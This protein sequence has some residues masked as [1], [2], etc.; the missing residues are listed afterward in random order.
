MKGENTMKG[1]EIINYIVRE[2]MP[3]KEQVRENCHRLNFKEE[4]IAKKFVKKRSFVIIAITAV[5]AV[6]LVTTA[7]AYGGE[8]ITVIQQFMFG[9]SS[10][11]QVETIDG[12]DEVPALICSIRALIGNKVSATYGSVS[13]KLSHIYATALSILSSPGTSVD[14]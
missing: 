1:N 2:K 3:D 8:I 13:T 9:E 4:H 6:L 11:V 7:F 14:M 12:G 10:A 5:L